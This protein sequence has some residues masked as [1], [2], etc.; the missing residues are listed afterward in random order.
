MKKHLNTLYVTTQ[1]AYLKKDGET[2]AVQIEGRVVKRFPIHT[3][4]GIV[5]FGNVGASPF[6]LG[7]C[8]ERNV[9]ITF[10]TEN[11]RFLAKV[12]GPTSGNV[13]L[14]MAQYRMADD[15]SKSAQVTKCFLIGKIFNSRQVL[16]RARRD[17]Q[18]KIDVKSV[19]T[20]SLRLKHTLKQLHIQSLP[21][22]TLRGLEGDAANSYFSTFNQLITAKRQDFFFHG[23]N[24]R[25]PMDNVNCL[26]SFI[27]T[28]LLHDVRSALET[29]GLDPQ[30]GFLHRNRPGRP[31]LALDMMEELRPFLADRLVLTLINL[32]QVRADGFK[33]SKGG[34][35]TMNENTRKIVL[36]AYQK[37]KQDVITHPFLKKKMPIGL[38]MHVQAQLLAKCIRG[39]LDGYPPFLWK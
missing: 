39:D 38:L 24:R 8:G 13:L 35:V 20:A 28:I 27:Y 34:A 1:G 4:D 26:L 21:L 7:F 2:I 33:K 11:G 19:Q 18:E 30:V 16:E 23:R 9:T 32:N 6:L 25:P 37:R 10:L 29:V 17:H 22:E 14:R 5:C 31:S 12:S 15:L 36:T 3:I